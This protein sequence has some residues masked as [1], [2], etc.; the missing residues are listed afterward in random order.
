MK[1]VFCFWQQD[2]IGNIFVKI[3]KIKQIAFHR[4]SFVTITT[5]TY[6]LTEQ[7]CNKCGQTQTFLIV[8][9]DTRAKLVFDVH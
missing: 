7:K 9:C 8:L 1:N 3:G 2:R 6:K 5:T 4:L